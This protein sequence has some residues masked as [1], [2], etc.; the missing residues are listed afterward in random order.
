MSLMAMRTGKRRVGRWEAEE[1]SAP[2]DNRKAAGEF[3]N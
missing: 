3:A 1:K 2:T